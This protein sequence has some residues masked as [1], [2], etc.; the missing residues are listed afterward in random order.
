[1]KFQM[2]A[3]GST[4]RQRFVGHGGISAFSRTLFTLLILTIAISGHAD[5]LT[6]TVIHVADGDTITVMDSGHDK[7]IIRL[8]GIDA[9]E[10]GQPFGQVSKRN[11]TDQV[12]EKTVDVEWT[13]KDRYGRT[14]GKVLLDGQDINLEQIRRGMAWHYKQYQREQSPSDRDGYAKAE[15]RARSDHVGLWVDPRPQAPWEFRHPSN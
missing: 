2:T 8:A 13:K 12:I 11:L 9:P 3:A 5:T 10:K 6:G 1:M 14:V 15:D 4:H 7:H